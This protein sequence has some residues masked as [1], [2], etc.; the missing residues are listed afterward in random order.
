MKLV[1]AVRVVLW[2]LTLLLVC[3]TPLRM[4]GRRWLHACW[5]LTGWRMTQA[6]FASC[7]ALVGVVA[8]RECAPF[9]RESDN[10]ASVLFQALIFAWCFVL[11][12]S[13]AGALDILPD[14]VVGTILVLATLA[15][16]VY[17]LRTA[18]KEVV[19]HA[20]RRLSSRASLHTRATM[21]ADSDGEEVHP[22]EESTHD[23][24]DSKHGVE[25]SALPAD[26]GNGNIE[27]TVLE[28]DARLQMSCMSNLSSAATEEE[29]RGPPAA[30][31]GGCSL[32]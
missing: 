12:M 9:R 30:A 21:T 7:I 13:N 31:G 27:L 1:F 24:D 32:S 19:K 16:Y 28:D 5:P 17:V 3:S 11:V 15:V 10:F 4:V 29:G 18:L 25:L 26:T 6:I 22:E 23:V 14:F 2:T 20:R 8:H